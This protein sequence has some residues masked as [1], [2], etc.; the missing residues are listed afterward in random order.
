MKR[1]WVCCQLSN[2]NQAV[3]VCTS[4]VA[5]AAM[6]SDGSDSDVYVNGYTCS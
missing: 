2:E 4:S 3:V 6:H 5:P 1:H